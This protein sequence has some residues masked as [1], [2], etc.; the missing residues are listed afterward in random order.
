MA[1]FGITINARRAVRKDSMAK[2]VSVTSALS[3]YVRRVL[4]PVSV[5]Y[6]SVGMRKILYNNV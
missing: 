4:V 2:I 5:I 1:I 6:V 3:Y